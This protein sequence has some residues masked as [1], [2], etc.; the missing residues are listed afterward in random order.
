MQVSLDPMRGVLLLLL[1]HSA[2]LSPQGIFY[3]TQMIM[4]RLM[5]YF[6]CSHSAVTIFGLYFCNFNKSLSESYKHFSF[7]TFES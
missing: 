1:T 5:L 7:L 6:L 4:F 3:L 2:F